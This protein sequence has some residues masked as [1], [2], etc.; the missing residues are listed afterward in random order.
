MLKDITRTMSFSPVSIAAGGAGLAAVGVGLAALEALTV[1][2]DLMRIRSIEVTAN[3]CHEQMAGLRLAHMSDLHVMGRGWRR[4]T[5][6]AAIRACN[7]ADVDLVAITGDFIGSSEGANPAVELLSALRTD[8]PRVAVLGNHDHVYGRRHLEVLLHGL[9]DLGIVVLNNEAMP[10]EL[11]SGLLWV[12]GV[13]DGYSLRDDLNAAIGSLGPDDFPRILLTHY[14]EVAERLRPA[15]AQLSLAG[16]SHAGQIRVPILATMMYNAHARTKYGK[17]L[18]MVNGNPLYVT[19]GVG[20][21]GIPMRFRN[22]PEVVMIRFTTT[23]PS[24]PEGRAEG[25]REPVLVR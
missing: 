3:C 17:G 7:Q 25:E 21:S 22:A 20:M 9:R 10:V 23:H 14:A 4:G 12:A 16:H 8:V 13:D 2:P 5:I 15:Q 6:S 18:F 24:V 1:E 19:S 11:S